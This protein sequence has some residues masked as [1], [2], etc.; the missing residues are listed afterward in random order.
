MGTMCIDESV[1]FP[2]TEE[3]KMKRGPERGSMKDMFLK[4]Y[5]AV[6]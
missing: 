3:I 1:F 2:F 4:V 5:F 6:K